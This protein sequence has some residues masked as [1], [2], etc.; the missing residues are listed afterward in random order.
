VPDWES[1]ERTTEWRFLFGAH[2][3]RTLIATYWGGVR[4]DW[5]Y[6]SFLTNDTET[7][8][9]RAYNVASGS[10]LQAKYAMKDWEHPKYFDEY[11]DRIRGGEEIDWEVEH[12]KLD[13]P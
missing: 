3:I 9:R 11:M 5:A 10:S 1:S 7:T 6:A 8:L 13:L 4:E 12:R 2:S